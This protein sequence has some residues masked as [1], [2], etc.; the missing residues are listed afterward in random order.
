MEA[1]R[2]RRYVAADQDAVWALHNL[3]LHHAGVHPGNGPWDD[4][5]HAIEAIY[6]RAGGD[7]LVGTV[8][9]RLVA[10]GALRKRSATRAELVRMRVHP[11]TQRRGFGRTLLQRLEARARELGYR[12]VELETTVCQLPARALYRSH[13]FAEVGRVRR[14]RFACVRYEKVLTEAG[15]GRRADERP[16]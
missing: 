10:M 4:D 3:V 8:G 9:P 5:L 2:I 1:L 11:D 13:G 12:E 16:I 14:G 15:P 7:F 6:L